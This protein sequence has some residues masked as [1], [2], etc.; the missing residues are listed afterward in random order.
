MSV[1]P[2]YE[3]FYSL[4]NTVYPKAEHQAIVEKVN[5]A[6][7]SLHDMHGPGFATA[8]DFQPS[9]A[10]GVLGINIGRTGGGVSRAFVGDIGDIIEVHQDAAAVV[11]PANVDGSVTPSALNY[12]YLKRDGTYHIN[13]T[14]VNPGSGALLAATATM[15]TDDATAVDGNPVGRTNIESFFPGKTRVV[16]GA[17]AA[18][19]I[20]VSLFARNANGRDLA[21]N[22]LIRAWL[23]DTSGG[24]VSATVPSGGIAIAGAVGVL[25]QTIVA[26]KDLMLVTRA[27]D[28]QVSIN[29]T[30]NAA[31]TWY[32]HVQRGGL[33]Q[34]TSIVFV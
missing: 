6:L 25:L 26:D 12:F 9:I 27:S 5:A 4:T 17:E 34:V 19:V 1:T 16:V 2:G 22:T 32:L 28:G 14:G 33:V 31:K 18:N 15:D 23:S 7:Q 13:T 10:A 3:F 11:G 30:H 21:D 20:N 29:I 24:G 8:I